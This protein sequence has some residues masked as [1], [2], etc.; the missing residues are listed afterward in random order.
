MGTGDVYPGWTSAVHYI[1]THVLRRTDS[2]P[3]FALRLRRPA[4]VRPSRE[5][6]TRFL[7]RTL[8]QSDRRNPLRTRMI[9]RRS[10]SRHS[11]RHRKV[12]MEARQPRRQDCR[13]GDTLRQ[14]VADTTGKPDSFRLSAGV[15]Y[16]SSFQ[17]ERSKVCRKSGIGY[18]RTGRF[19]DSDFRAYS[20]TV[21]RFRNEQRRAAGRRRP[22]KSG[23]QSAARTAA[24]P[25]EHVARRLM[26]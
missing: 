22:R 25:F 3:R 1:H 24:A 4:P 21:R 26:D 11:G 2:V 7:F 17:Y 19:H 13:R 20:E 5:N 10:G 15:Y 9:Q 16:L 14:N 18:V 12:A 23:Q 6:R 8:K